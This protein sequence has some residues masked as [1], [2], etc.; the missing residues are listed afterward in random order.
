[1]ANDDLE[2]VSYSEF[3]DDGEQHEED[4]LAVAPPKLVEKG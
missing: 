3:E 1:M 2:D 4:M